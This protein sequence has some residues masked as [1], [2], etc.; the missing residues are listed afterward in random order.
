MTDFIGVC[1]LLKSSVPA[2][3]KFQAGCYQCLPDGSM[4]PMSNFG[5]FLRTLL[6][7]ILPAVLSP[8]ISILLVG[9]N[10]IYILIQDL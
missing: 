4:I 2:A 3:T 9:V 5:F 1:V 6:A 7:V 8:M 10:G